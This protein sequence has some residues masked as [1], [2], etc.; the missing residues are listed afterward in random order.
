MPKLSISIE[1]NS[2]TLTVQG[3]T[4]KE[5]LDALELLTEDFIE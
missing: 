3:D 2:G 1:T 4:Q 5:V